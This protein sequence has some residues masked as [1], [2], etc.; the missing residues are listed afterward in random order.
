MAT[1]KDFFNGDTFMVEEFLKLKKKYKLE[2][3]VETGTFHG[4]TTVFFA[5]NFKNTYTT[6]INEEYYNIA[7]KRFIDDNVKEYIKTYLS[8]SITVLPEIIDGLK[9]PS[10]FFLDAHWYKNPLLHE[11][12]TIANKSYRPKVI[13]IHDIKNPND[14]SMGYDEYPD[15]G[16]SY[17]YE[18]VKSRI[19]AIYG[20]D[21][22]DYYF[23]E[24]A[25]GARRGALF[26]IDK[27][28]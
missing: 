20:A 11:L 14:P 3:V 10:I 13:C 26:I 6:E 9:G 19:D 15:Q 5:E 1:N 12:E 21:G 2:N 7:I 22:Y 4:V 18:W 8:D 25:T 16:I 28:G 17:N 24:Q 23:N 27:N